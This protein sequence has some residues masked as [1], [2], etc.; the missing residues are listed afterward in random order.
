MPI[1]N[2][3]RVGDHLIIDEESGHTVY[4]SQVT[5]IWNGTFRRHKSFEARQPQEFVRAR[6]DPKAL[7]DVRPEAKFA[8][9]NNAI[10]V[11]VDTIGETNIPVISNGPATH[12][13]DVGIGEAAVGSSFCVR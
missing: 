13:Y 4:R 3:H 10:C 2:T 12:L 7:T 6:R 9:V 5:K 8:A 11:G 1:R